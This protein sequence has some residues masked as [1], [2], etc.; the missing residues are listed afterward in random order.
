LHDARVLD[1]NG[2]LQVDLGLS[3]RCDTSEA[4]RVIQASRVSAAVAIA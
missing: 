3:G 4:V 1:A 2:A